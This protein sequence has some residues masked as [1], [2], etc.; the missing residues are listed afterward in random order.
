M[1]NKNESITERKSRA[2]GAQR[3][4]PMGT[5]RARTDT[6]VDRDDNPGAGEQTGEAVGGIG[7]TLAGAGI[8][9]AAGPIG[10]IVGGIAGALGGWWVGEKAGRAAEDWGEHEPEYRK[11]Y[12]ANPH[13][14]MDFERAS[15]GYGIGHIAGRNPDYRD[16]SFSDVEPH[17][18]DNWKYPEH[19]YPTMRPYVRHGFERTSTA[20]DARSARADRERI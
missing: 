12:E 2:A 5:E 15:V 16:R 13:S 7:G 19:D 9:S 1:A 3:A 20:G 8:G 18:R 10:T 6:P 11:H 14:D 4:E 17:I